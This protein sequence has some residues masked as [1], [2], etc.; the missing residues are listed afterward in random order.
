MKLGRRLGATVVFCKG[1]GR[2]V[3][4]GARIKG[5]AFSVSC[6]LLSDDVN[7]V[8]FPCRVGG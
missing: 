1:G 8:L 7:V 5:P 3:G 2:G 6:N 4:C